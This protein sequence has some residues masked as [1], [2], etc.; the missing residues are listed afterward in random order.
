MMTQRNGFFF[1]LRTIGQ[2]I[3][4]LMKTVSHFRKFFTTQEPLRV[5][6]GVAHSNWQK[7]AENTLRGGNSQIK[8]LSVTLNEFKIANT[9]PR[10]CQLESVFTFA[11]NER[12]ACERFYFATHG[13]II[14]NK[15]KRIYHPHYKIESSHFKRMFRSDFRRCRFFSPSKMSHKTHSLSNWNIFQMKM[16]LFWLRKHYYD[17]KQS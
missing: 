9:F 3:F 13:T 8:S 15:R 10:L 16:I 2:I 5:H 12:F 7:C 1:S 4:V 11:L 14:I 6:N 17:A